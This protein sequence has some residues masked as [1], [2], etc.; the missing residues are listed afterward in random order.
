MGGKTFLPFKNQPN[1]EA[2][3][4]LKH[5]PHD[6]A[7]RVPINRAGHIPSS[8]TNFIRKKNAFWKFWTRI[9]NVL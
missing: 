8:I 4:A 1:N 6:R 3:G 7:G 9:F 2:K 5:V